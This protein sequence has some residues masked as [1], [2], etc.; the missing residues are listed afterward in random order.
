L[1]E[2]TYHAGTLQGAGLTFRAVCGRRGV[3]RAKHEGDGATPAGR[4]ALRRVLYR[5][6][7]LAEPRCAVPVEPIG[8]ADGWCDDP[9]D[10]AYNRPI[11]LPATM[12]H[13]RLHREDNIYDVI[14]VLGWN[15][16]PVVPG[17]GSAI[18]V[19]VARA[20][21]APTDG[22]VALVLPELLACLEV[23]LTEIFVEG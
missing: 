13:E 15:M 18:F 6:D 20:D 16:D 11:R 21:F 17:R 7:R 4:H 10:T 5:A 2:F 1:V 12:H 23:G 3:T 19:H 9:A 8:L 14:G 22:C